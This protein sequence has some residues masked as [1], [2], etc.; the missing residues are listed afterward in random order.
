MST[1]GICLAAFAN[2]TGSR[3]SS[4]F[5]IRGDGVGHAEWKERK[6]TNLRDDLIVV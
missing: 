5:T 1:L 6:G 3:S 4:S 2:F